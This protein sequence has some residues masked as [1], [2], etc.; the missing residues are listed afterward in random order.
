A[1]AWFRRHSPLNAALYNLGMVRFLDRIVWNSHARFS[2]SYL[3]YIDRSN[4]NHKQIDRYW[5]R[6]SDIVNY[7]E[8]NPKLLDNCNMNLCMKW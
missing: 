7:P 6:G 8:G 5:Y 4:M 2:T 3:V 1:E